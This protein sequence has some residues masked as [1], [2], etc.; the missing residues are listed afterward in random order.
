MRMAEVYL[1]A[2]EANVQLGNGGKAAEYLN[3]LR[4]RACRD[5]ADYEA[6][7]KLSNA[8]MDDVFDEYARELCGEYQRWPLMKRH[9]D[10]FESRLAKGNPRAAENFDPSK[11]YLRPVSYNFLSQ[12]DNA[13]EYGTNGY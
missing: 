1:L 6:H 11:H 9:K 10:S 3:V 8:T 4:K 2:A 13:A 7:M 5:E 12:I